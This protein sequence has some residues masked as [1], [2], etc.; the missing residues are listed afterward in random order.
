MADPSLDVV[1]PNW[2]LAGA[3]FCNANQIYELRQRFDLNVW[4]GVVASADLSTAMEP[5]RDESSV[6]GALDIRREVVANMPDASAI[7]TEG[8]DR[9]IKG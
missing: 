3:D 8:L 6:S 1:A 2:L 4:Y 9:N 7:G 5:D